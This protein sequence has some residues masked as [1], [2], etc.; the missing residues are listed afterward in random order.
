MIYVDLALPPTTTAAAAG[1]GDPLLELLARRTNVSR[2]GPA[3]VRSKS[4]RS[5]S[6]GVSVGARRTHPCVRLRQTFEDR[7]SNGDNSL[8]RQLH[9]VPCPDA[10]HRRTTSTRQLTISELVRVTEGRLLRLDH[11]G[12]NVRS[13]AASL[14]FLEALVSSGSAIA[15]PGR[16]NWIF[17][18]AF[19]SPMDESEAEPA[20]KFEL[21]LDDDLAA[22]LVQFDIC[23]SFRRTELEQLFPEPF[24]FAVP[25][26]EHY[27]RCVPTVTA[28][29]GANLRIDLRFAPEPGQRTFDDWLQSQGSRLGSG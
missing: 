11:A 2:L 21:V 29:R 12:V 20:V 16:P 1:L 28:W 23:T 18:A 25:G 19:H 6:I 22:P 15:H 8:R 3:Q 24:G 27:F 4:G 13:D 9:L 17:L 26:F 14:G 10:Q 7:G 5:L